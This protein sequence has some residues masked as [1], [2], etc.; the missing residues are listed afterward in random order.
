MY[1]RRSLLNKLLYFSGRIQLSFKDNEWEFLLKGNPQFLRGLSETRGSHYFHLY[2]VLNHHLDCSVDDYRMK[3]VYCNSE[4]DLNLVWQVGYELIS[5]FNGA[6]S[7]FDVNHWKI[8]IEKLWNEER[9]VDWV[10]KIDAAGLLGKPDL[11]RMQIQKEHESSQLE[12]D[13]FGFVNLATENEDIYFILKYFGMEPSWSTYY[14]LLETMESY[15]TEAKIDLQIVPAERKS[16]TNVANNF[17]L[18]GLNS[19]HGFKQV[20]KT[21]KTQQMTLETAHQFIRKIARTYIKSKY[22]K[23]SKRDAVTGAPS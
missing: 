5:L 12:D 9:E 15:A 16:F 7:L 3:S 2:E 13:R 4:T 10:G 1:M 21:N 6:A 20:V 8:E 17:S 11:N 14:K 18:S 19:R 23:S 22:N